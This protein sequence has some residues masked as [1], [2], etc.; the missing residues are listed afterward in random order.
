MT[1]YTPVI[2]SRCHHSQPVRKAGFFQAVEKPERSKT[3]VQKEEIL[4]VFW[5]EMDEYNYNVQLAIK[6]TKEHFRGNSQYVE[7][8]CIL[9]VYGSPESD[10]K[11]A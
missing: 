4:E 7:S 11:T 8:I 3:M 9:A 6:A 10:A 1:P 2:T 5:R